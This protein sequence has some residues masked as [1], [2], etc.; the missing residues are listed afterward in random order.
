MSEKN[1][2]AAGKEN[3]PLWFST[4]ESD[5]ARDGDDLC[6]VGYGMLQWVRDNPKEKKFSRKWFEAHFSPW[7]AVDFLTVRDGLLLLVGIDPRFAVVEWERIDGRSF[8]NESPHEAKAISNACFLGRPFSF[9]YIPPLNF[10]AYEIERNEC[11]PKKGVSKITK[12]CLRKNLDISDTEAC[13]QDL[14]FYWVH[15]EHPDTVKDGK[16]KLD[17]LIKWARDKV[18]FEPHWFDEAVACG[19]I[20]K[21]KALPDSK[22]LEKFKKAM[23]AFLDTI[24]ERAKEKGITIDKKSMPGTKAGLHELAEKFGIWGSNYQASTFD[25]YLKEV[26]RFPGGAPTKKDNDFYRSLYP[27]LFTPETGNKQ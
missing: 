7:A 18:G 12:V 9:F 16:V 10:E 22:A 17:Y 14:F 26:C 15:T 20:E 4:Y 23:A 27:E 24:I 19:F 21:N 13:L 1:A 8:V 2:L 25:G 6:Y 3:E 5:L 11:D